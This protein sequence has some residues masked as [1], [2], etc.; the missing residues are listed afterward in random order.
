MKPGVNVRQSRFTLMPE[1]GV[2]VE[3]FIGHFLRHFLHLLAHFCELLLQS[4]DCI[5]GL[6]HLRWTGAISHI[7]QKIA[8]V[9]FHPL[10]SACVCG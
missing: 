2:W 1:H 7:C 10:K 8:E 6:T 3:V 9:F 4:V 5:H